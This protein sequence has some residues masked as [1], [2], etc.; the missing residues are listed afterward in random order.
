MFC[1]FVT[2]KGQKILYNKITKEATEVAKERK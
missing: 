2:E 1:D